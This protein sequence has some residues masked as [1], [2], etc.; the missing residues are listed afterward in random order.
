M[1]PLNPSALRTVLSAPY[2]GGAVVGADVGL[3]F[4]DIVQPPLI[5]PG[6]TGVE[7][8]FYR[9]PRPV[10]RTFHLSVLDTLY[11]PNLDFGNE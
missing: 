2:A 6:A 4:N 11:S 7:P 1:P 9:R 10:W 5:I 3:L 8:G